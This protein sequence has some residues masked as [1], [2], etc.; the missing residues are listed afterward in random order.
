MKSHST[1][2]TFV[3]LDAEFMAHREDCL[4]ADVSGLAVLTLVLRGPFAHLL[5]D[6]LG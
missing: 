5:S 3:N 4:I 6:E 1:E 2:A